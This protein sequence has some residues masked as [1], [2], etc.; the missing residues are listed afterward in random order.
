[1]TSYL[2]HKREKVA[3]LELPLRVDS[4]T[5]LDFEKQ[6]QSLVNEE[7][8]ILCDFSRN[9]YISSMGLRILLSGYKTMKKSG[10]TLALCSLSPYVQE[11]FDISGFS[12]LFQI[13]ISESEALTHIS[14]DS[15]ALS[16]PTGEG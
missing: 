15:G 16:S 14:S 7:S 8:S 5:A 11:V 10:R 1:M 13:Y 9:T 4:E 2:V 3:V 12:R 6:L